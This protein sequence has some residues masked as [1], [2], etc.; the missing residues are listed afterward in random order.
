VTKAL[1]AILRTDDSITALAT[2]TPTDTADPV[3]RALESWA[4]DIDRRP[5]PDV[6]VG[7]VLS[8]A[9]AG[10]T[11]GRVASRSVA[12]AVVLTLSS[13]G[14]AAAVNGDPWAPLSF[15]VAKI[16]TFGHGDAAGRH[17]VGLPEPAVAGK[18]GGD[19]DDKRAAEG[20]RPTPGH[21]DDAPKAARAA[22]ES[23][24]PIVTSRPADGDA[25]EGR[26][27]RHRPAVPVVTPNDNPRP[28]KPTGPGAPDPPAPHQSPQPPV[29]DPA[30]SPF[31]E[32]K[33]GT[34]PPPVDT[35]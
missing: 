24:A 15:V 6:S 21:R 19:S 17:D 16:T 27:P 14:V 34:D 20:D 31:P 29:V 32:P 35:D 1:T 7:R 13:T 2:R 12:L 11:A 10:R 28:D 18:A 8:S 30:D 26:P 9:A 23:S 33:P 25:T 4:A 5:E 22:T 3:L